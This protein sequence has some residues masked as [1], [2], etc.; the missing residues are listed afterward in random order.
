[1][2]I[3]T[4]RLRS[5]SS[6]VRSQSETS[7]V[8]AV[9]IPVLGVWESFDLTVRNFDDIPLRHPKTLC[10]SPSYRSRS[11]S[12]TAQPDLSTLQLRQIEPCD[13]LLIETHVPPYN[14][15]FLVSEI[16]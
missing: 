12:P 14:E 1:M 3:L 2:C 4:E 9:S 7:V 15:T 11:S 10:I 8:L 13:S 6:Q 16:L 5:S